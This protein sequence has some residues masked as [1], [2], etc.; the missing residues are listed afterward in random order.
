[1]LFVSARGCRRAGHSSEIGSLNRAERAETSIRMPKPKPE[2]VR[3]RIGNVAKAVL[4]TG[5]AY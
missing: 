4:I 2:R 5:Q 3:L 1:M